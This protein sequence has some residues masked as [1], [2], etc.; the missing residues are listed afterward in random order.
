MKVIKEG[1]I[2]K[3]GGVRKNW[4]KRFLVLN[5]HCLIYYTK[6]NQSNEK[7]KINLNSILNVKK[8]PCSKSSE[9]FSIETK[10]REFLM[11]P[12]NNEKEESESW[13]EA[14]KKMMKGKK[15][16]IILLYSSSFFM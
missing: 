2:F 3:I 4:K 1:W 12:E 16:S 7:G 13:I 8:N 6:E 15:N 9:S 10:G 14:I 5:E 11:Y